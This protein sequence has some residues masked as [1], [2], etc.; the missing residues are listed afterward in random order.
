MINYMFK[1]HDTVSS[2][3]GFTLYLLAMHPEV[4]VIFIYFVSPLEKR[5]VK[6]DRNK[7]NLLP[8]TCF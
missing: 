7:N 4:Q 8:E 2:A 5:N 3:T 6:T 1:G